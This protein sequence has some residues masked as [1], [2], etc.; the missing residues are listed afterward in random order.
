ML[1]RHLNH[2][3]FTLAAIDDVISRGRWRDWAALRRAALADRSLLDKVERVCAPY[4]ADPYAQRH[5]FWMHY[6]QQHRP[7]S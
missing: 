6:V 3:R 4:I 5:H 1:H 2:Q 7:A